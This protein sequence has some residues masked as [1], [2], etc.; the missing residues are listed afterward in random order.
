MEVGEM[1]VGEMEVGWNNNYS[2]R[3]IIYFSKID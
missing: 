3:G 1:E 2:L